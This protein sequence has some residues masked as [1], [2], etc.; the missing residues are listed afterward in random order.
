MVRFFTEDFWKRVVRIR[1]YRTEFCGTAE[2]Q[3][4]GIELCFNEIQSLGRLLDEESL[5]MN[6]IFTVDI[7]IHDRPGTKYHV[8]Q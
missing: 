6:L 4:C 8:N 3:V 7:E 5:I 1:S 2:D